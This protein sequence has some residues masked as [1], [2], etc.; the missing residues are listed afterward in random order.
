[1][2]AIFY[3]FESF[4]KTTYFSSTFIKEF[5]PLPAGQRVSRRVDKTQK[6]DPNV[7]INCDI[8]FEP[9]YFHKMLN[10]MRSDT[11]VVE[12]RQEDAE[13]FLCCLLNGMNDEMLE[14]FIDICI[15]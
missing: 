7:L 11:F 8:P 15:A 12:G 2:L 10:G 6:Q 3:Q 4:T 13:E 5:Q 9:I 1:M 14:V